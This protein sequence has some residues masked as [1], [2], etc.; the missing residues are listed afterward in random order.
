MKE[1]IKRKMEEGE[2][3]PSVLII[4]LFL[5]ITI[6]SPK[7]KFFIPVIILT[8]FVE[9]IVLKE[10]LVFRRQHIIMSVFMIIVIASMLIAK[11]TYSVVHL[12]PYLIFYVFFIVVTMKSYNK[13]QL[14]FFT[15]CLQIG[16][17]LAS[18]LIIFNGKAYYGEELRY[19]IILSTGPQDPNFTA[20]LLCL[21]LVAFFMRIYYV[22]TKKNIVICGLG[23]VLLLLT[24]VLTGSRTGMIA[25]ATIVGTMFFAWII[26]Y[27]KEKEA[28]FTWMKV[29]V[30]TFVIVAI[31]AAVIMILPDQIVGRIFNYNS[32]Y[33]YENS[34]IIAGSPRLNIWFNSLDLILI[35]PIQG[36]GLGMFDYYLPQHKGL[37]T[38]IHNT[39]IDVWFQFGIVGLLAFGAVIINY[40]IDIFRTKT[41]PLISLMFVLAV[42]CMFLDMFYGREIWIIICAL[43]LYL[44]FYKDTGLTMKDILGG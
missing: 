40:L 15:Y 29:L 3:T 14:N 28:K 42:G 32:L 19:T 30:V 12:F 11:E 36:F 26:K 6:I 17:V 2:F 43:S 24:I 1:Y 37:V 21:P 7:V 9:F 44:N 38:A 34:K 10:K 25:I 5:L 35:K 22:T 31:F 41:F 4:G 13:S 16:G 39:Y 23:S 33:Q 20:I 18:L 8:V 27:K